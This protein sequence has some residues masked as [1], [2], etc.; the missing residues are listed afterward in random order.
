MEEIIL[1]SIDDTYKIVESTEMIREA[2]NY[3]ATK[4]Q[5]DLIYAIISLIKKE[6]TAFTEYKI[7]FSD[8][9]R[10]YNPKNPNTKEIKKCVNEATNKIMDS[11]FQITDSSGIINKYH[12]IE[13]C[14]IDNENKVIYF[15]LSEDVRNFYLGLK[16]NSYTIYLLKDLLALSTLFQANLFR[17]LTCHSGFN[18]S[19]QIKIEDA[20]LH[21][22]GSVIN[23]NEFVRK[24]DS[25]LKVIK[26]KTCVSATYEKIKGAHGK[27]VEL[28]FNITNN[29][30]FMYDIPQKQ[31]TQN[32]MIASSKRKKEMW[33]ENI[34]MKRK[35][36]EL[37]NQL[38]NLDK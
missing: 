31:K 2:F 13:K 1:H 4:R 34:D 26:D 17:W 37:E 25:A 30:H 10:I 5:L 23:G 38:K 8:I 18:N 35:I 9:A 27:I 22:Y 6:D 33:K 14:R 19:I 7:S 21:F 11:H 32:E 12:W 29:Y 16:E 3:V 24:L 28:K 36:A 15:K 20:M